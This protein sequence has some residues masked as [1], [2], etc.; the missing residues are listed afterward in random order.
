[1]EGKK[2]E[3]GLIY[4]FD[5]ILWN[6]GEFSAAWVIAVIGAV[7]A[8]SAVSGHRQSD[9]GTRSLLLRLGAIAVIT[10]ALGAALA[11]KQVG[12]LQ[13]RYYGVLFAG[14]LYIGFLLWRWQMIRG[15]HS[16]DLADRFLIWGVIAVLVGSRL[17]HVF[18]Y[19]P[20]KYL[21]DPVSILKVWEGGLAS[22][23]ATI[24]LVAA[25]V[26][27]ALVYKVR[28]LEVLDR[29]SMPSAVGA[30]AVRLGNFLNSEIVG[31]ETDLPWAVR[32]VRYDGGAVARHPSQLY[33][34]LLGM[35]VLFSLWIADRAA[36]REKRPL[37]LLAG[38]FLTI[39][40]TGRFFVEFVKE[41]QSLDGSESFL[42]MGQYLSI[43]PLA[44]GIVLL[45]WVAAKRRPTE[46]GRPPRA[47]E[48]SRR[49]DTKTNEDS[50]KAKHRPR[51]GKKRNKKGR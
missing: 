19:E 40:F 27:F 11:D 12:P 2:V 5:P 38:L 29:F 41:Y 37:G 45:A 6:T 50:A 26:L 34:F 14:M 22:H 18:F 35:G 28:I 39:Y 7:F 51:K 15:G 42:T 49:E 4:D 10:I 47:E 3:H 16:P 43:V 13:I 36:G 24:G 20:S 48:A 8:L 1:M 31:R 44:A 32:F 33:E 21:A 23:G 25:L 9:R 30:A 17:G 46:E